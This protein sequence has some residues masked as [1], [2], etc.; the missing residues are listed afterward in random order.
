MSQDVILDR[1]HR[2]P[3]KLARPPILFVP[4]DI[5]TSAFVLE[6]DPNEFKD[7]NGHVIPLELRRR[8]SEIGWAQ[9]DRY[10][11][12]KTEWIKTPI[13]L[14]PS[15]QLDLLASTSSDSIHGADSPSPSPAPSPEATPTKASPNDSALLR[16]D[17]STSGRSHGAKR[18]PVFVSTLVSCLPR[19]ISMVK[20]ED[21]M[22]ANAALNL[23]ND[24]MRDDPTLL[25]R[26]IFQ[27]LSGDTTHMVSAITTLRLLLHIH[28]HL[29]P[30]MAYHALNH[31]AGFLKASG[32]VTNPDPLQ[33]FAYTIAVVDKTINQV[34]KVSVRELRRAKIDMYLMPSGSLWFAPSAPPGPMFPRALQKTNPFEDVPS[35]LIWITLIRNSQNMLFTK[36]LKLNPLDIRAIRKNISRLELPLMDDGDRPPLTLSSYIPRKRAMAED[37][38]GTR[39]VT[40]TAL[41]LTLARSH[42]LLVFQI[43][44]SVSR[45]L[46]DR[47]ELRILLDGVNQILLAHGDDIG[48][49]GH[50][51]LGKSIALY[52]ET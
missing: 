6:E 30:G 47:E 24:L 26:S 39:N 4:T 15:L 32:R 46:S 35:P 13:S 12:P 52:D 14:L 11:D 20:D 44:Q 19:L 37:P 40:L 21:F 17:S 9:E 50:A 42:L 31:L 2:R 22:V 34:S 1:N 28:H 18:R 23:V 38:F 45:H 5:G 33:S 10:I 3:F 51:M 36:L 8:L 49:V 7:S 29:P 25:S 43:F 27:D 41:S 16:R 48:I